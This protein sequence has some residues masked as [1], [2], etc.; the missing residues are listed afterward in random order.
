M[1]QF[2]CS[3]CKQQKDETPI[4]MSEYGLES[5]CLTCMQ[6]IEEQAM[7]GGSDDDEE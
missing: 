1:P 3:W 5:V 6:V 2:K 7:G 4:D